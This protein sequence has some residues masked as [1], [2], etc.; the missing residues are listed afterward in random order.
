MSADGLTLWSF[1]SVYGGGAKMGV[2]AHDQ[3]NLVKA[4]LQIMGR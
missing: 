3:F 4:T 2:K 1:F